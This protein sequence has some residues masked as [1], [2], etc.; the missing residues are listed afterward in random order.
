MFLSTN[1]FPFVP[2]REKYNDYL[3]YVSTNRL[4]YCI[5]K[6]LHASY[7]NSEA[8][9]WF[10]ITIKLESYVSILK[11]KYIMSCTTRW[12]VHC[13]GAGGREQGKMTRGKESCLP[14]GQVTTGSH[15]KLNSQRSCTRHI[16]SQ[17][18]NQYTSSTT[19]LHFRIKNIN[20]VIQKRKII[21]PNI[22]DLGS[23]VTNT[24]LIIKNIQLLRLRDNDVIQTIDILKRETSKRR[25]T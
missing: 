17:K 24:D 10:L 16:Q 12:R 22:I 8:P 2:G 4:L 21:H 23:I 3:V 6:I 11:V 9:S 5:N 14:S 20:Y 1:I 25:I 18:R 19:Q 7:F 15:S 13:N